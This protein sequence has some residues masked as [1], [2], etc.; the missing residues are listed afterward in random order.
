MMTTIIVWWYA[1]GFVPCFLAALYLSHDDLTFKEFFIMLTASLSLG[2]LGPVLT[3]A[4]IKWFWEAWR[5]KFAIDEKG[6]ILYP[7]RDK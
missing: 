3:F 4:I 1:I 7:W 2:V 5:S 6:R